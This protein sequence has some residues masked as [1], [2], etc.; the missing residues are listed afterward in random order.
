[1]SE[2]PCDNLRPSAS[3]RPDRPRRR[4]LLRVALTAVCLLVALGAAGKWWI[5]PAVLRWQLDRRLPEYWDGR[6]EL[7]RV[8][9]AYFGPTV[10]EGLRLL[11]RSGRT[12]V[13]AERISVRPGDWP[14]LHPKLR[15]LEIRGLSFQA[16]VDDGNC[17]LP[18]R[19]LPGD[20]VD[21]VDL[22]DVRIDGRMEVIEAGRLA[23]RVSLSA[24]V[25]RRRDG[26][27]EVKLDVS[28]PPLAAT[29]VVTR[30]EQFE[31]TGSRAAVRG[32]LADLAGGRLNVS[33]AAEMRE[34]GRLHVHGRLTARD[35]ELSRVRLPLSGM[36][37]GRVRGVVTIDADGPDVRT[38]RG[39]G[40]AFIEAL[41]LRNI[42]AAAG[43]FR[44]AGL[45][46]PSALAAADVDAAWSLRGWD[47]V[48]DRTRVRLRA[49][50]VDIEPGG[51]VNVRSGKMDLHAAVLLLESLRDVARRVPLLGVLTGL[52]D[53]LSRF[54][55]R[56]DW[57][58]PNGV[59]V[60]PAPAAIGEQTVRSLLGAAGSGQAGNGGPHEQ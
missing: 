13:R 50:A 5:V 41:D 38:L 9:F 12:W 7:D 57:G 22:H 18:L 43:V 1:M 3:P 34:A 44:R 40:T 30:V 39:P 33:V 37:T 17:I 59:V 46:T 29:A 23:D 25:V 6:A 21:Y 32:L 31:M 58:D 54:R 51:T 2:P 45:A 60:T 55:V 49:G 53:R 47:V 48:L 35:V 14:G 11:D 10:I 52:T 20:L 15:G 42:P 28:D 24:L 4:R 19:K 26:G 8:R 56:G 36:T 16:H 27:Y